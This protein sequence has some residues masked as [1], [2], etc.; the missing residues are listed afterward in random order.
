M[1]CCQVGKLLKLLNVRQ[2]MANRSCIKSDK[3]LAMEIK[4]KQLQAREQEIEAQAAENAKVQC[5]LDTLKLE[6]TRE[7][8]LLG[9]QIENL[10]DRNRL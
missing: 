10:M 3:L 9:K 1:C 8:C 7:V 4:F 6:H 5:E 2:T